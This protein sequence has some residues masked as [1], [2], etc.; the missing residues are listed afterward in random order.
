LGFWG[1]YWLLG[2]YSYP[3]T[4]PYYYHNATTNKNETKPVDCLCRTDQECGC[5]DNG[6]DAY[7]ATIIGNGTYQGLDKSVVNVA[8]VNGT[9]TIY[10]NGTLP[11][12]TTA[13]GGTEDPDGVSAAGGMQSLLHTAGWLPIATTLLVL[14]YLS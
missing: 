12:G 9:S 14:A 1:S 7:F 5:D 3:Y 6:D 10:I 2:A 11:N 4:H 13:S 8:D